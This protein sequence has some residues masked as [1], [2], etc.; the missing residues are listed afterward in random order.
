M[1]TND[2][3]KDS[4]GNMQVVV[5]IVLVTMQNLHNFSKNCNPIEKERT[6]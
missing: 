4:I 2:S 5:I 6:T 1:V 3:S